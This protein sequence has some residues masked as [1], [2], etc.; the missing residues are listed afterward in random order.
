MIMEILYHGTSMVT[1]IHVINKVKGIASS[2]AFFASERLWMRL[3]RR[4]PQPKY[5]GRPHTFPLIVQSRYI[6]S[7]IKLNVD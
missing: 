4:S 2:P 6:A 7:R 3:F 5:Q 1:S